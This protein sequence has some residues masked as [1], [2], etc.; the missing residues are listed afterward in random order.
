MAD[1]SSAPAAAEY[2]PLSGAAVGGFILGSVFAGIL[3]LATLI[4][5]IQ[6]QPLF[7]PT[8]ALALAVAGGVLSF[9]GQIHIRNSE[10]T[11]AGMKLARW[12][13]GLCVFLGLGYFAYNFVTGLA[14]TK[15]A[16][17]FMME[18]LDEH[19][20][21]FPTLRKGGENERDF[22]QA[23]LL[24]LPMTSRIGARPE[25]GKRMRSQFDQSTTEG[26]PGQL[27]AFRRMPLAG[28]MMSYPNPKDS[29]VE[30]LGVK[31]WH[32][33]G[34]SYV[35]TRSYRISTPEVTV[36]ILV[37]VQSTEGAEEGD[38]R[39]WFAA[40][41]K[42]QILKEVPTDL[43]KGL[44]Y[45][46]FQAREHVDQW[47]IKLN[48]GSSFEGYSE[49]DT[50]DWEAILP[51]EDVRQHVKQSLAKLFASQE[52]G[53]LVGLQPS[54]KQEY[55]PWKQVDGKVQLTQSMRINLPPTSAPGFPPYG[56]DF[57]VLLETVKP[58][59]PAQLV[60]QPERKEW[61]ILKVRATRASPIIA[62]K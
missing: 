3:V 28:L 45:L 25:D 23:F 19:S 1:L 38:A 41:P 10:G 26:Q 24:T 16:N 54:Q 43:G 55:G 27:S 4:A 47:L 51:K 46:R 21:F 13:L 7:L 5:L 50:P 40:M 31:E 62:P 61:R 8:W 18:A 22:H 20:G 14:L 37:P 39:R 56:I 9:V 48:M 58:C 57:D 36:E 53:R 6:G 52:K 33:E 11:R 12:G 60:Q 17:D 44:Q 49:K 32:Y 34:R 30:P 29:P 15:Q 42:G 2:R 59:D 35:V